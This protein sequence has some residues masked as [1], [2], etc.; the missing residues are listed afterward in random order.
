MADILDQ[1][2]NELDLYG[3]GELETHFS[4]RD[5]LGDDDENDLPTKLVEFWILLFVH[6]HI[7]QRCFFFIDMFTSRRCLFFFLLLFW[8]FPLR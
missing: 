2:D 8:N 4:E 7:C 3:E 6:A 5:V 1:Q